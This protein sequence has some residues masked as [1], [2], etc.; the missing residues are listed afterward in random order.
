MNIPIG[1]L[2]SLGTL[3][4]TSNTIQG[5]EQIMLLDKHKEAIQNYIMTGHEKG[6]KDCDILSA[7]TLL[8]EGTP[9]FSM[10]LDKLNTLNPK[11]AFALSHCLFVTYDV[12][13]KA[14][15][16][17]LLDF[18]WATIHYIRLALVIKLDSSITLEMA[19]NT[20]KLPFLVASVS[21]Q[22]K[23]QFLC[24]VIGEVEPHLQQ[25]MCKP[26]YVSYQNKIL[27]ITQLGIP[28]DF[29]LTSSSGLD[30]TNIRMMKI[31]EDKLNFRAKIIVANSFT[32]EEDLVCSKT[33]ILHLSYAMQYAFISTEQQQ[34]Q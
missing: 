15:L 7:N 20:T 25:D 11:S 17:A 9:Q 29:L 19:T 6:W 14:S 33:Y 1:F 2:L 28:P 3:L 22:A 23:E 12:G 30:G 5:K 8:N 26:S 21:D 31:L 24:P 27:R 13:S 10:D 16:S 4:L 18:G 32:H 34:R